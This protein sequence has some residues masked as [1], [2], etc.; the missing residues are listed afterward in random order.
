LKNCQAN[1]VKFSKDQ[2][3]ISFMQLVNRILST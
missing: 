2:F 1:A 3:R